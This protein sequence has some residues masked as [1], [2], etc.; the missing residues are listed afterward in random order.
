MRKITKECSLFLGFKIVQKENHPQLTDVTGPWKDGIKKWEGEETWLR[1]L[2][3]P[4][5][6][7]NIMKKYL[8]SLKFFIS[9]RRVLIVSKVQDM[10]VINSLAKNFIS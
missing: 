4:V 2:N 8:L 10:F 3:P 9:Q 6:G 7:C 1:T 5:S